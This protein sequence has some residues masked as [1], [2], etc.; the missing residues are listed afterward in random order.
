MVF[1]NLANLYINKSPPRLEDAAALL[2]R[3]IS[4]RSD[5]V[6]AYQN[7]GSVLIK[8]GK[9][10][11]AEKAYRQA[12]IY[13]PKNADLNY[14]LGVVLL[15]SQQTAEG[16]LYLNTALTYNPH[17]QVF[18]IHRILYLLHHLSFVIENILFLLSRMIEV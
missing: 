2:S 12:L 5:F 4:L 15:E 7:Y 18:S 17:H 14:N 8:L 6:D 13:Q 16:L 1:I 9:Y 10:K 3:A 11:E